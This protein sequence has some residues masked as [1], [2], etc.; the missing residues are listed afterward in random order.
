MSLSLLG[1][2]GTTLALGNHAL[3]SF[4]RIERGRPYYLVNALGAVLVTLSS[5][6]LASWQ[7]V[8]VNG[9]WVLA[10]AAGY[11]GV[12]IRLTPAV[13][14]RALLAVC[15]V[16]ALPAGWHAFFDPAVALRWLGWSGTVL[17]C[18]SYLL[19]AVDRMSQ[20]VFLACNAVAA[21]SLV[22][23]LV[24]DQNWPVVLLELVWGI[25]SLIGLVRW[26]R[27]R[28]A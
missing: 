25:L 15:L 13:S 20:G 4:G 3:L 27:D 21:F 23:V 5:L 18:G 11:L 8:A 2:A 19:F 14:V 22:P 7:A 9:F 26:R 10:S 16:L 1:W 17:L 6:A 12:T 24:L 28:P